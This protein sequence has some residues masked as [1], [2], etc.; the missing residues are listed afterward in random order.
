MPLTDISIKNAE[1]KDKDYKL[2]DKKG[3]F[4][5]IKSSGRIWISLR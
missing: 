1:I 3:L 2:S 5:L 4:I